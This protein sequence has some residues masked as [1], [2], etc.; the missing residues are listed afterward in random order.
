MP[1]GFQSIHLLRNYVL[2]HK[3][4]RQLSVLQRE[5]Q[6]YYQLEELGRFVLRFDIFFMGGK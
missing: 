1:V 4:L 5:T 3:T 2:R 6:A